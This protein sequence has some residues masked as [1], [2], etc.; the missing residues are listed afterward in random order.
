M[1][2]GSPGVGAAATRAELTGAWVADAS[3][4]GAAAVSGGAPSLSSVPAVCRSCWTLADNG[5]STPESGS[6]AE[7]L[8]AGAVLGSKFATAFGSVA[9]GGTMTEI[10][11]L[12]LVTAA[13]PLSTTL[14]ANERLPTWRLLSG[15]PGFVSVRLTVSRSVSATPDG[16]T[17]LTLP[18]S[19]FSTPPALTSTTVNTG[20]ASDDAL[21]VEAVAV[22][23]AVGGEKMAEAGRPA[24][25]VRA[26]S[27]GADAGALTGVPNWSEIAEL[28]V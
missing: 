8:A 26:V 10:E 1:L 11:A 23:S 4:V 25:P 2:V 15:A 12:K 24:A 20:A 13:P 18:S 16:I 21:L 5:T 6:S 7:M 14:S 19:R 27:V 17:S 22:V 9:L 28:S 3:G